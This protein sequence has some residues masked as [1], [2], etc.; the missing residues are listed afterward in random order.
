M[1]NKNDDLSLEL[2]ELRKQMRDKDEVIADL[3]IKAANPGP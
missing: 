2:E 3:E 1:E